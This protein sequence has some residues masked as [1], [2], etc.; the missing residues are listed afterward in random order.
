M[1]GLASFSSLS[2]SRRTVEWMSLY[3][4]GTIASRVTSNKLDMGLWSPY[5]AENRTWL[6]MMY[7]GWDV[8]SKLL[9]GN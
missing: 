8:Y 2:S 3:L 7:D 9:I 6:L 5:L 4:S 1:D